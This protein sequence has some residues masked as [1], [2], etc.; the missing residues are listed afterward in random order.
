MNIVERSPGIPPSAARN[1]NNPLEVSNTNNC[2]SQNFRILSVKSI[3]EKRVT[4]DRKL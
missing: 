1:P 2:F 3:F 4:Q